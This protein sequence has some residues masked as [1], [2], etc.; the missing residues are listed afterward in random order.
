M[1]VPCIEIDRFQA[2][3]VI[4]DTQLDDFGYDA[5][6]RIVIRKDGNTK[7]VVGVTSYNGFEA[8]MSE[9][10]CL[11]GEVEGRIEIVPGKPPLC[12][13]ANGIHSQNPLNMKTAGYAHLNHL[14]M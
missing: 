4:C 9:H 2:Q 11:K 5:S 7:F 13:P 8:C 12:F 3:K 6:V 1:D 14:Y 10:Y